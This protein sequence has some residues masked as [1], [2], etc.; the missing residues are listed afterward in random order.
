MKNFNQGSRGRFGGG[1]RGGSRFGSDRGPI[2]M[3]KATCSDCGNICEVPFR[4]TGDKPIFCNDCF[5]AKRDG[6]PARGGQ[7]RFPRK[8][9]G[10]SSFR[11]DNRSSSSQNDEVKKQ[12]EFLGIK[13]DRLTKIVENLSSSSNSMAHTSPE[14]SAE[15]KK[16]IK[17][18][19]ADKKAKKPVKK[20][21]KKV[22]KKK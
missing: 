13:I 11:N 21:T 4:P 2:T 8:D 15:V 12:L 20:E 14:K 1:S 19:K 3:H 22:S 9:S 10:F 16:A 18:A 5:S 7:N 17:E 6:A